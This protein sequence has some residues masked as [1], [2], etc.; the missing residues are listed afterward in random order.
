[1][2]LDVLEAGFVGLAHNGVGRA[3]P[4]C[5]DAQEVKF[6]LLVKALQRDDPLRRLYLQRWWRGHPTSISLAW[7]VGRYNLGRTCLSPTVLSRR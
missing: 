2:P 4:R 5:L 1:M 7:G 3:T 6:D